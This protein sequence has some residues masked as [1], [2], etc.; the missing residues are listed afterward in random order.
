MD[1]LKLTEETVRDWF[2]N[3]GYP[4]DEDSSLTFKVIDSEDLWLFI[5]GDLES[6][7]L[8]DSH[9]EDAEVVAYQMNSMYCEPYDMWPLKGFSWAKKNLEE[10]V[11]GMEE[12]S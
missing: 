3:R 8:R 1:L 7:G 11:R 6:D 2:G 12:D 4:I 9:N 5:V 10:L